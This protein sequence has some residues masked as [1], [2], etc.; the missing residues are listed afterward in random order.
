MHLLLG[1]KKTPNQTVE[2]QTADDQVNPPAI[3]PASGLL[4][5]EHRMQLETVLCRAARL[6][7]PFA[8]IPKPNS[9]QDGD[10]LIRY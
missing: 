8:P 3:V 4:H 1:R 6:V 10:R 9:N 7:C 5:I 2:E